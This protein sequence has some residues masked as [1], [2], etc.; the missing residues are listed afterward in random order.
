MDIYQ[1]AEDSEFLAKN[2]KKYAKGIV[3]DVGTGSGILAKTAKET[4]KKVIGID[5]NQ[6]AI[7]YCKEKYPDIEFRKSDLF[8][9][10]KEKFDLIVFNPPYLPM[11]EEDKKVFDP[12]LFGGKYGWEIVEKF[13]IQAKFYLKPEGKILLLISSLTNQ[14]KVEEILA[15]E[16]YKFKQIDELKMDFER[17][18]IY[19]I[20]R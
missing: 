17:L 19:E 10:I 15:R 5:I 7:K 8:S 18:Y 16:D 12:A 14:T 11:D 20:K 3:L 6:D 1:P 13:L 9:N 4:A 2:V